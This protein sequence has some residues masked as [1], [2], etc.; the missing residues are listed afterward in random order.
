[1][2][3]GA[4]YN[5]LSHLLFHFMRFGPLLFVCPSFAVIFALFSIVQGSL[6]IKK[7]LGCTKLDLSNIRELSLS[8]SLLHSLAYL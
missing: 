5:R 4:K 1:M 6:Y 2:Y 7:A 8:P 3:S